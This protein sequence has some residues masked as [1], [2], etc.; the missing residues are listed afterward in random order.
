MDVRVVAFARVR[1]LVGFGERTLSLT[2]DAT[3]AK[4]WASLETSAHDLAGL[5]ASTRFAVN[6]VLAPP[7]SELHDGDELAFLPPVGG[8]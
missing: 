7:E 2:P 1:E 6:G 3:P 8:G 4:V 5:R